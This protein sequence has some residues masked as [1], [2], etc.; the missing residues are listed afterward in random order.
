M[1][2]NAPPTPVPLIMT[3]PRSASQAFLVLL[4]APVRAMFRPITSPLIEIVRLDASV[5]LSGDDGVIFSSANGVHA[6]PDGDGRAAFCIGPATTHAAKQRGWAAEQSG[7]DAD[8]LVATL[9]ATRPGRRLVHLSGTHTRGDI[10][11]RLSAAGL[12]AEHV[13]LYDQRLCGL[14]PEAAQAISDAPL[15]VVP[16]FSPRTAA[17]FAHIAPR[18]SSVHAVALSP[19]VAGA[20]G[21]APLSDLTIATHPDAQAMAA[22]LAELALGN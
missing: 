4:P 13:A 6:A 19:A 15:V 1:A 11:A 7:T 10:A 17:Q 20:L 5:T 8:S 9:I 3:R 12:T 18:T 21:G 2:N 14:T 16:L 22:A